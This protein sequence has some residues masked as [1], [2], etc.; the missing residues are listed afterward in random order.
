MK[1]ADAV[2]YRLL[3]RDAALSAGAPGSGNMLIQGDNL[4]ALKSLL[5]NYRGQVKCIYIDP[6]YNTRSAVSVHYDDTLEHS[7]WLAMIYPRLEL[8]Q[9]LLAEDGSIWVSID[10][11]EGHYLK[12]VMD[13]V[14]GRGSFI[15]SPVW[16]KRY[17]RENREAIG[18][19]HEYLLAYSPSPERFK[20]QR[21]KLPLDE[22]Q[23]KIYRNPD[24]A[25]EADPSKRWRGLPMT[26]QGYRPNQMYEI[27][28]PNGRRHTPPEG[29][30]W[31]MI[32]PEFEKLVEAKRIYWGKDG[33]AQPSV[34]RFLSE[35]E[36]LVPWTWWPHG[37]VG[38]TDE[39]KKEAN[40]LFG[41]DVSFGTPKPE[42]LL[43]RILHIATNPGDLVLDSF[44]GSG[45]TAA[46]AHKMGR[47]WIGIEMGDH[48]VTH[49]APR[50]NKVIAGEGGG[51][52]RAV[53][54][55]GGGGFD[56]YRLGPAVFDADGTI[57]AG[58]AFAPLAAHVWFAETGTPFAGAAATPFLGHHDGQGVA[59]LY[60]GILG[61]KR[62]AGGNV[63]TRATL[64]LIREG[65]EGFTG[66]VTIY[67][68]ASRLS[69]ATLTA[70]RVIFKQTPYDVKAR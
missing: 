21:N 25:K 5:P 38:H 65:A 60:N 32:R 12:I 11:H 4:E 35:V 10:D 13:E 2:P 61:D 26:A 22:D 17:S 57:A 54:W 47:R 70:E 14:F 20:A 34:I 53:D 30:C 55:Q 41:A 66:P 52:S 8:L 31:S 51:I 63:L 23:A 15:A 59:L 18:D 6:P 67:G 64:A 27:V 9:K 46:V 28:A 40:A 69:P 1:A 45:T 37:E 48:A 24:N 43:Q 36:G 19:V 56:F 50:L 7:Q 44:L 58:I 68:E 16:Q 42:R 62:P 33:N 39:S 29:R 49:C 3:E